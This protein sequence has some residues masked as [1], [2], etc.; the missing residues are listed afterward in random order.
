MKTNQ[1]LL[2]IQLFKN[3]KMIYFPGQ[4][5]TM[6]FLVTKVFSVKNCSIMYVTIDRRN[7]ISSSTSF[8]VN[9]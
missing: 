6:S 8:S 3:K 5:L 9:L 4:Y 1:H 2:F 7:L